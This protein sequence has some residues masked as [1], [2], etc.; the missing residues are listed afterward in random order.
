MKEVSVFTTF[1]NMKSSAG[2]RW[3][4]LFWW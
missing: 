3:T 4:G 1:G 2:T